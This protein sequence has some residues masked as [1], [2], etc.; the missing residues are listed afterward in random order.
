MALLG[1]MMTILASCGPSGGATVTISPDAFV[2]VVGEERALTATV[3][4][5]GGVSDEVTWRSDD[6]SVATVNEDGRVTAVAEGVATVT[7][8]SVDE[9]TASDAV[10]VEVL[11]EGAV[12]W[13]RRVGTDAYDEAVAVAADSE[14]AALVAGTTAGPMGGAPANGADV[15]VRKLNSQG[16]A[17]WTHQFGSP[18]EDRVSRGGV[19]VDG[20]DA[21]LV[22]GQVEGDVE[23]HVGQTDALV[24]KLDATGEVVWTRQF[25]TTDTDEVVSVAVDAGNAIVAAGETRGALAGPNTGKDD[26]FVRKLDADGAT[27]WTRQ[28]GSGT[29]DYG[30]GVAVDED[31]YV[32]VSGAT[33]GMVGA[34][35]P[36][37]RDA[38]VRKLDPDGATL[39]TRQ[40]GTDA[41]DSPGQVAADSA[42]RVIVVGVTEGG[43]GGTHAGDRDVFVRKLDGD[44]Q[45][46]WTRQFGTAAEEGAVGVAVDGTDQILVAGASGGDLAGPVAGGSDGIVRKYGR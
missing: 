24:R 1:A 5:S 33:D 37:G 3:D 40:F 11:P 15:Y 18:G 44:G 10:T 35:D 31:G 2:L 4:A 19:A 46:V 29:S 6:A 17:L 30:G 12:R 45:E 14:N 43:L 23:G 36:G 26:A 27:L 20:S 25:G 21:V 16:D 22:G 28:F 38:F 9:P 13:T 32:L 42:G 41:F 7:A 39:W 8:T 34:S